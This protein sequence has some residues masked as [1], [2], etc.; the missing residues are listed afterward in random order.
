MIEWL[1]LGLGIGL[2]I[3][4]FF[5][6]K[7]LVLPQI[8]AKY[9]QILIYVVK[10]RLEQKQSV[11][12]RY[13]NQI[14]SAIYDDLTTHNFLGI[15]SVDLEKMFPGSKKKIMEVYKKNPEAFLA[16]LIQYGPTL[17]KL[18]GAAFNM[19]DKVMSLKDGIANVKG[20]TQLP[21]VSENLLDKLPGVPTV[22]K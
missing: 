9:H 7:M 10:K 12:K 2:I 15:A 5:L 22:T 1:I 3:V 18:K 16:I 4:V 19:E 11:A 14:V 13:V 8:R 17:I 20:Q 6:M 21:G